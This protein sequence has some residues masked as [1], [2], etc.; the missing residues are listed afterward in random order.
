MLSARNPQPETLKPAGE[1]PGHRERDARGADAAEGAV[2][3]DGEEAD[4]V[5][6]LRGFGL[7][8]PSPARVWY[9]AQDIQYMLRCPVSAYLCAPRMSCARL[10]FEQ[11]GVTLC[12]NAPAM[13]CAALM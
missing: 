7:V 13:A 2:P 6:K 4:A 10:R 5:T 8:P 1:V 12:V 9:A 11:A 3:P